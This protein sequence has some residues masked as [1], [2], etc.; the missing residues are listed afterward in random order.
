MAF[1][2]VTNISGANPGPNSAVLPDTVQM[3]TGNIQKVG[4]FNL[5]LTPASVA[6][7]TT[8][9]QV[10]TATGIGLQTT[11]VVLVTKPAAQAGI[12]IVNARVSANDALAITYINDTAGAIVPTAA[13][14][15]KVTV[16]RIQPNWTQ[17]PTGTPQLDW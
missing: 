15:Y 8:A 12:G 16:I 17:P 1:P 5:T 13:E 4:Y 7:N 9:E 11:D 3:P 6:A 2:S 14:V 10:F